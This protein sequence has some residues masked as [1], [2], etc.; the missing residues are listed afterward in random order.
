MQTPQS[1]DSSGD[2]KDWTGIGER[3]DAA[4][5]VRDGRRKCLGWR[6]Q[7]EWCGRNTDGRCGHR[8]GCRFLKCQF[9]EPGVGAIASLE[10]TVW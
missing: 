5:R 7:F 1:F 10:R 3:L 4:D 8:L 2:A 9:T 6:C